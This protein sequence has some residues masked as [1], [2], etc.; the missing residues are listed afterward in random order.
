MTPSVLIWARK[1]A[2]MTVE[3]AAKKLVVSVKKLESWESGEARPTMNQADNMGRLY[4]RASALFF[5]PA[6]PP[7]LDFQPI[8]D[9]RTVGARKGEYS[10]ALTFM[11]REISEK[12]E[13]MREHLIDA[14]EKELPFVG[15]FT[16]E[17]PADEIARDIVKELGIERTYKP[18]KALRYWT[19]R[20]EAKRI[21][22]SFAGYIHTRM[23]LPTDEA[24][25]FVFS[26]KMA[27][28]IFVN[29]SDTKSAQ[30]FTL[31]H[32]IAHLWLNSSAVSNI[33]EFERGAAQHRFNIETQCNSVAAEVLM[34]AHLIA[35]AAASEVSMSGKTTVEMPFVEQ[36]AKRFGVS[37]L[38]MLIRFH[39]MKWITNELYNKQKKILRK[40]FADWQK[41]KEAKKKQKDGGIPDP[42]RMQIRRNGQAFTCIIYDFYKS[43]GLSSS[44]TSGLLHVKVNNFPK[45]ETYLSA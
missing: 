3:Y 28:F 20:A 2:N 43:G 4:R 15:R 21:F 1:A 10:T 7:Q 14:G 22:V 33:D 45:L 36:M 9:F 42:Y 24:R 34:P 11:L 17:A 19:E 39:E 5:L 18:D 6:P 37:D 13:W 25:G 32:E 23:P 26:D 8:S 41:E 12:Q 44:E 35:A 16:V 27:P 31:V 30:L 40:R 29:S 38:A